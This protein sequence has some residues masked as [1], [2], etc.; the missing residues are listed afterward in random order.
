MEA[1]GEGRI[2]GR[3]LWGVPTEAGL[4]YADAVKKVMQN[5]N[6]RRQFSIR[7]EGGGVLGDA[8]KQIKKGLK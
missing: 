7:I 6:Y 4:E 5:E 8:S 1:G 3:N 2:I